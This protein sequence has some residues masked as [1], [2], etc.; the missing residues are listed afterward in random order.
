MRSATPDSTTTFKW[1]GT[2]PQDLIIHD[3]DTTIMFLDDERT[4]II[5]DP[6]PPNGTNYV[7]NGKPQGLM[8]RYENDPKAEPSLMSQNRTSASR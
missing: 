8:N 7:G 6:F 5:S 4:E 3:S 1:A 2:H